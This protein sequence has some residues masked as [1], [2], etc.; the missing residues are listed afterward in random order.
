MSRNRYIIRRLLLIFPQLFLISVLVFS[1]IRLVPGGPSLYAAEIESLAGVDMSW[2]RE[3]LDLDKPLP[4]QYLLWIGKMIRGEWGWSFTQ[5]LPVR[6]AIMRRLGPTLLLA[7]SA[8]LVSTVFAI[9]FGMVA[10][11]YRNTVIDN[12]LTLAAFFSISLPGFWLG[13]V[14]IYVFAARLHWFPAGNMRTIGGSGGV[15]DVLRHLVLPVFVLA[16]EYMASLTRYMRSSMIDVLSQDYVRTARAK[17]LKEKTVVLR[18]AAR[19]ALLPVVTILGLRLPALVGG[20]LLIEVVFSWPG[21][22]RMAA[23]AAVYRDYPITA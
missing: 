7:G 8:L 20:A 5:G 17:G 2:L 4:Q 9:L 22:G 16:T 14:T 11:R 12:L 19:N 3:E 13:I 1:I 6:E 21:M 15:L 23:H 10:A 18:H